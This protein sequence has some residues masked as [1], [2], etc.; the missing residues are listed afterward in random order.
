MPYKVTVT[1]ITIE[2]GGHGDILEFSQQHQCHQSKNQFIEYIK[3]R[4][5]QTKLFIVGRAKVSLQFM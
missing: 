4:E 5:L 2:D 3:V 1:G